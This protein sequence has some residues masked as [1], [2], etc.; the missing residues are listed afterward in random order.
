MKSLIKT[1]DEKKKRKKPSDEK[2]FSQNGKTINAL[3]RIKKI[4][5][6]SVH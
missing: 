3:F 5:W 2:A 4:R 1:R 6:K